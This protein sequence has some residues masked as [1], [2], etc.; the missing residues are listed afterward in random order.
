MLLLMK[1]H[2]GPCIFPVPLKFLGEHRF[3]LDYT[4]SYTV[5]L[6]PPNSHISRKLPTFIDYRTLL[7]SLSLPLHPTVGMHSGSV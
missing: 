3:P 4:S 2:S 6:Q 7:V 5:S 1:R